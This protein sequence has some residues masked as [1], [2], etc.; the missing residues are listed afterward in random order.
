MRAERARKNE[1]DLSRVNMLNVKC[2]GSEPENVSNKTVASEASR[3]FLENFAL[4]PQILAS[5][6]QIIY[7]LSRRGQIIY[8][9]HFQGQNI[10]FQK[11]PA[12]SPPPQN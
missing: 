5:K 10:Y 8:F 9:Q 3:K 6:G 2:E 4:F 11:V 1:I 12:P 7:F